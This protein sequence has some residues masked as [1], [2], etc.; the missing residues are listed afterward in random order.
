M[1][2]LRFEPSTESKMYK[3]T[4]ETVPRSVGLVLNVVRLGGLGPVFVG[5]IM[6]RF[7]KPNQLDIS[8]K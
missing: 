6:V 2:L 8:L 1:N 4:W 7:Y 5:N 3:G